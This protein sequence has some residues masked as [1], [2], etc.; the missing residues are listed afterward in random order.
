MSLL[1]NVFALGSWISANIVIYLFFL[2][3]VF[4]RGLLR[5]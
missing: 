4:I 3:E 2:V 1:F 5:Y